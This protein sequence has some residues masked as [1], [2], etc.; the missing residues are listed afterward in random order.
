MN[1]SLKSSKA[2]RYGV[3]AFMLL[4]L[5]LPR[6]SLAQTIVETIGDRIVR[7]H[8]SADARAAALPSLALEQAWPAL[9]E[10][11]GNPSIT[12]EFTKVQSRHAVR[13]A[14]A[15]GTSLYGTGEV[16]GPLLRN[17]RTTILWNFD[18]YGWNDGTP[19]LYQ[20][21]PWVLAVRADGSAYGL[22]FD[23]TYRASL[24]LR[25]GIVFVA[26][27]PA[28][29]VIVIERDSPQAVVQALGDLTGTI[30]LP[31]IWALGYHQC[32]Y[33]Y[34]PD[35]QVREI[36][37]GFRERDIPCDVIWM[38]IDYMDGFRSF[39][40][41]PQ[42]F[43]NPTALNDFLHRNG[44]HSVWMIDPGIKRDPGY[45]V[46]DSGSE[47][48]AWVRTRDGSVFFGDV[49]PGAC[50]FPDFTN[51]GVREWWGGLYEDFI[52]VGVDGVWND[53]NE[54]AVFNIGGKTMPLDNRH[55]GDPE[56]GGPGTHLRYHNVYGMLMARATREGIL[57]A[58]PD[59][60]PFVLTR[61]NHLGG[62]RYAAT[63]TGDNTSDWYHLEVSIP[64]VLNLGLSGQPFAG[65]DIGGFSGNAGGEHFARWM[66]IGALLPFARGH[67]AKGNVQ[68]EP[69]SFGPAVERTCRLALERRY[70]LLPYLYTLFR[71]SSVSGMPVARPLFFADPADPRLRGED[72]AFLLGDALL[73]HAEV[74]PSGG[75]P[76]VR[77]AGG[78]RG[79]SVQRAEAAEDDLPH[80]YLKDGAILPL[81]PV[82][83]YAQQ[84]PLNPVELVV[85]LDAQG[86]ASGV[87][88][89]D[90]GDG[91]G[92]RNDEYRLTRFEAVRDGD[93]VTVTG[94]VVEGDWTRPDRRIVVRLLLDGAERVAEGRSDG[95]IVV[96]L[97]AR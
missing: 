89:E 40:F 5:V 29:P 37:R 66:G 41:D 46:F 47:R 36:A 69:W 70:R 20:S 85:R 23:T 77:P 67:T 39:T 35:A 58:R 51:A 6:L 73:V 75:R 88:Y 33:S 13:A 94:S 56:F 72:D 8:A 64:Q 42:H 81:G 3:W 16:P 45:H 60:R 62:H 53:M 55:R 4:A 86:R 84:A 31:P 44:F 1:A 92:Y 38:D 15:Q 28:F 76:L 50:V 19:G 22:L 71:E 80:L 82:M 32:R 48:D 34:Y 2:H 90:A 17:G 25:D 11:A 91:F 65:P 43:P 78:W 95:P 7:V 52:A 27:G 10:P 18:A 79:F 87:L 83:E 93:A 12:L 96:D 24:D 68:K 49:W 74:T 63:W 14:V 57:K 26:D 54:P 61:A 97:S 30:E 59:R 9:D 21:H